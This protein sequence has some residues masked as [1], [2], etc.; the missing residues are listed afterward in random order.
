MT[1]ALFPL[2]AP[3]LYSDTLAQVRAAIE[4]AGP[5]LAPGDGGM[6][7]LAERVAMDLDACR[8]GS[9]EA[10]AFQA[11]LVGLLKELGLSPRARRLAGEA[12][13]AAGV[14]GVH[15]L[16]EISRIRTAR[17]AAAADQGT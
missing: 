13:P 6:V 7:A 14:G 4:A 17:A 11:Q 16:D 8:I 9:R 15:P 1:D 5:D 10:A 2:P 3:K 12:E